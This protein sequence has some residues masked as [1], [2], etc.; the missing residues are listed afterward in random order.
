MAHAAR[1]AAG[2]SS[3]AT[4]CRA[5][6]RPSPRTVVRDTALAE[7][8]DG[9]RHHRRGADP[10]DELT[11]RRARRG[12]RP[13][14][15]R[16]GR[17]RS[18][19][20]SSSTWPRSSSARPWP[21]ASS[22]RSSRASSRSS[23]RRSRCASCSPAR[24][25]A[26]RRSPSPRW[27]CTRR[28]AW[29]GCSFTSYA[30]LLPSVSGALGWFLVFFLVGFLLIACLW[31]VAGALAS[32]TEDVQSTS[33]PI[34]MLLLAI[35]FGSV[36]LDGTAADRVVLRAA[37]LGGADAAADPRRAAPLWWEP[38]V[39]LAILLVAA[40]RGGARG[41]AALPALAAADAGPAL[42]APG[43]VRARVEASACSLRAQVA[44]HGSHLAGRAE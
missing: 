25:R 27:R 33:T 28:S 2:C 19:W 11:H 22:R 30:S 29:W 36:F 32:R 42:D 24:C 8:A 26:T 18:R 34:T 37:G 23:R 31:A 4:R 3:A 39:A 14:R 17:W 20:R 40:A 12:R 6:S 1:P 13:A 38:V 15:L 10:R 44:V 5:T 9:R 35:F 41:R 21:T 43:V 16:P 7:N